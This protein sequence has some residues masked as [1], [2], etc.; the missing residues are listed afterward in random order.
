V[1][2]SHSKSS[3]IFSYQVLKTNWGQLNAG[4]RKESVSVQLKEDFGANTAQLK[5]FNPFSF[6]FGIMGNFRQTESQDG[7]Q[8]NG[9]LSSSQRAPKDYELFAEGHH[10]ATAAYEKGSASIGLERG[11]QVDIGG[12]WK[13][14]VNKFSVTGFESRFSNFISLRPAGEDVGGLP[15]YQFQGVRARFYGVESTAKVRMVGGQQALISQN[16]SHGAMDLELRAD[17]VRATDLTNNQPLPRIAPMRLGADLVWSKNAWG[18][19]FGFVHSAAQNRV[20]DV[21]PTAGVTTASHTLWNAGLNY[22][23]HTGATHWM[24]FAKLDNITDKLAYSST[25]VLTQTMG[26]N[27]PPIAGRSLKIG[28]QASF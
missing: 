7:W 25:S 5:Q 11:T 16:A 8:I 18:A 21:G 4:A 1:G 27:A 9:N 19:R 20:P 23:T 2:P 13:S 14:G 12:D 17:V 15:V 28:L 26:S 6:S 10:V 3:A 24:M 22:H